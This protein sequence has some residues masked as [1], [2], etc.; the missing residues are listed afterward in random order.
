MTPK[1]SNEW[2]KVHGYQYLI[3]DVCPHCAREESLASALL[4]CGEELVRLRVVLLPHYEGKVAEPDPEAVQ[5]ADAALT[6]FVEAWRE[7]GKDDPPFV[8]KYRFLD[9][10]A[11]DNV[12]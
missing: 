4:K 5:A 3:D 1:V 12:G 9:E 2:C 6:K 8:L 10:I 7:R 11:S